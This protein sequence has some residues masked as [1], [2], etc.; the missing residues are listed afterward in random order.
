VQLTALVPEVHPIFLPLR[1]LG[2]S[3]RLPQEPVERA[4]PIR[5]GPEVPRFHPQSCEA[6]EREIG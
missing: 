6:Q 5:S 4:L 2:L 3:A 1:E